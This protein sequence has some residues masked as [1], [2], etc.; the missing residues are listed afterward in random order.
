M[1]NEYY[2][3][4]KKHIETLTK[5]EAIKELEY[6]IFLLQQD[7]YIDRSKMYALEKLLNEVKE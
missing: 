6:V 2:N 7:N 3:Q 4:W 5:D 1:N